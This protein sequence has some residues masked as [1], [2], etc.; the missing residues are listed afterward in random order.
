MGAQ[1]RPE[2]RGQPCGPEPGPLSPAPTWFSPPGC[3]T[4]W[5]GGCGGRGPTYEGNQGGQ[6][7][8]A[9]QEIVKLLQHQLPQGLSWEQEQRV[10]PGPCS[11][12][13]PP[14]SAGTASET[15]RP[16]PSLLLEEGEPEVLRGTGG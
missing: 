10:R 9:H 13:L 4:R 5:D 6:H 15:T 7:Q 1:G 8:D 12:D 16:T 2:L 11:T 3:L 14:S